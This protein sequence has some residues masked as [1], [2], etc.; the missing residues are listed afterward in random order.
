M[1]Y[2]DHDDEPRTVSSLVTL[3]DGH[4]RQGK[5]ARECVVC[6]LDRFER[7]LTTI[8]DPMSTLSLKGTQQLAADAFRGAT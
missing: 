8:A 2:V 4:L 6:R 7:A 1:S 3:C 5:S